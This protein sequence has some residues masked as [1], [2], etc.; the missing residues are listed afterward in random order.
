MAK[1]SLNV[2]D[3]P[4]RPFLKWAGN[5]FRI[6][7]HIQKHLPEGKRL[8]EP[9]VGSGAVFLN[10]NYDRYLLADSNIDL[11]N[12]YNLLKKEG[13]E[14]IDYCQQLFTD[15]N[16]TAETYYQLRYEFNHTD[17]IERKAALFIYLNRHGYNGLCRY[18]SKGGFN[19][20]FGRYKRPYF[21]AAE[22]L[23][24]HHKAKRASFKHLDF[25]KVMTRTR[26]GDVIYCDPPYV[27]LSDSANFTSYS[28]GGFALEQ[29]HRLAELADEN[30]QRGI[31]VLI[32]NHNTKFTRKIYKT[33]SKKKVFDV[34]RFISC[35]GQKRHHAE[36]VLAVFA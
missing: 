21:P 1:V 32:S 22:M 18:N 24:F 36:E 25:E 26:S 12:L 20:P 16:N 28:A 17:D 29:Q 27:P 31:P 30:L 15:D 33:A 4:V 35:N 11:I 10:S 23:H 34:R 6:L 5:K 14:F 9:F 8:V 3:K 2:T 19:V 13:P 7:D